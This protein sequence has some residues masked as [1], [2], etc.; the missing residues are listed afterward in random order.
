MCSRVC[1]N[2]CIGKCLTV[3]GQGNEDKKDGNGIRWDKGER[4]I[5]RWRGKNSEKEKS[6]A[7]KVEKKMEGENGHS[8]IKGKQVTRITL[9]LK[10]SFI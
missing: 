3:R 1:V 2:V 5:S 10:G 6:V 4:R 8:L 7:Y 9:N